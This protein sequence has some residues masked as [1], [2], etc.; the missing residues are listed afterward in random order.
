MRMKNSARASPPSWR[1]ATALAWYRI[2]PTEASGSP[3]VGTPMVAPAGAARRAQA[4]AWSRSRSARR[5][6]RLTARGLLEAH[7]HRYPV[8]RGEQL[9]ILVGVIQ[10][11]H[12]RLAQRQ[13]ELHTQARRQSLG[14]VVELVP[15]AEKQVIVE[16]VFRAP[17]HLLGVVGRMGEFG[18]GDEPAV[19]AL[20]HIKRAPDAEEGRQ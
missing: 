8:S 18:R 7:V 12:G 15:A 20:E 13:R 17:V 3:G 19:A 9:E 6:W 5:G 16:R 11:R 1:Y 10:A 14:V 4:R 2:S